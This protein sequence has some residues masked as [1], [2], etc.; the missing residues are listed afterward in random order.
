MTSNNWGSYRVQVFGSKKWTTLKD[1]WYWGEGYRLTQE[2][3]KAKAEERRSHLARI[4]RDRTYRID[5]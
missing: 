5:P 2:E 4:N 3:A 1:H